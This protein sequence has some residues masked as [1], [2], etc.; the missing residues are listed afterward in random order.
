MG[1]VQKIRTIQPPLLHIPGTRTTTGYHKL[2]ACLPACG[3][4]GTSLRLQ[5]MNFAAAMNK[6]NGRLDDNGYQP[7]H[8]N[9][10]LD[11]ATSLS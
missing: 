8:T 9:G 6:V 3:Y 11:E 2:W 4:Y 7:V 10:S 1:V 5:V